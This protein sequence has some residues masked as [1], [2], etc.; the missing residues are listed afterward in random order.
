MAVRVRFDNPEKL[1]LPGFFVTTVIAGEEAIQKLLIPQQAVQEDQ[2]GQ[3]VMLVSPENI[4][5]QRRISANNHYDGQLIVD[6]GLI[7]NDVIIIEGIQKVR[8]GI[9]V[10]PQAASQPETSSKKLEL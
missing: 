10:A 5:E 4:V 9:T 7:A 1:L 8:P 3:F 6:D 2:A